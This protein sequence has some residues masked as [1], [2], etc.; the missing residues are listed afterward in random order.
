MNEWIKKCV[1]MCLVYVIES[2]KVC[3]RIG[4]LYLL[5]VIFMCIL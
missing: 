2:G 3:D 4:F 5:L 1:E